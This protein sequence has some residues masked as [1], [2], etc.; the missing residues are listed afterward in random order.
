MNR[1][2]TVSVIVF[3]I[4]SLCISILVKNDYYITIYSQ[5]LCFF[6][7]TMGL[8]FITGLAGQAN[9]GSAGIFAI[10]AYTSA[11]LSTHLGISPWLTILPVLTMGWIIGKML[12]YP[13]LRLKGVY[14]S[15][16]T[17]GFSEIVRM[18]LNNSKFS[19]GAIG[20]T[21]IP[22]F[23]FFGIQLDSP[24]R[25]LLLLSVVSA[26]LAI[27]AWRITNSRYG[28]AFIAIRDNEDAVATC[29]I[30]VSKAKTL[31]FT[32]AVIY[33]CIAGYMYAHFTGYISPSTYSVNFSVDIVVMLVLGGI[34]SIY[35]CFIGSL[36]VTFLPE[37]LRFLGGYYQIVYSLI[38][39]LCV[40]F[41]PHGIVSLWGKK[42]TG[43]SAIQ[44]LKSILSR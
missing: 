29:G 13:S 5:S 36:L 20:V 32:V 3:L 35:G 38:V 1:R 19:G 41:M 11:L 8:N 23:S 17:I 15:I 18:F 27:I 9:I 4:F 14:L 24:N 43:Y 16:T 26:L 34:G 30:N 25:I 21:N 22:P 39:M 44:L 40:V 37:L 2:S 12:G 33:G 28:R 7:A 42:R 6:M 10:G 31:A